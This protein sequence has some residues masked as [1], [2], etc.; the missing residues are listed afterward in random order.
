MS[1]RAMISFITTLTLSFPFQI[2]RSSSMMS[3]TILPGRREDLSISDGLQRRNLIVGFEARRSWRCF[4]SLPRGL[5]SRIVSSSR[6]KSGFRLPIPNGRY[7]SMILIFSRVRSVRASSLHSISMVFFGRFSTSW[8]LAN[9]A[10]IACLNASS[11]SVSMVKPAACLWPQNLTKYSRQDSR[12]SMILHHSGDRQDAMESGM[13]EGSRS[14]LIRGVGGLVSGD[15][16]QTPCVPL[17]RGIETADSSTSISSPFLLV[18]GWLCPFLRTMAGLLYI[19]VSLPATSPI[20]P[21]S[22]SCAS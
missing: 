10:L 19:S 2:L 3:E 8:I 6:R 9:L 16:G 17:I 15:S 22:R 12:S 20:I 11:L 1:Y 13:L 5:D 7:R 18:S 21:C 4:A 14:P